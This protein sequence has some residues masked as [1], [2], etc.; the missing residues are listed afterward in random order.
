MR[1]HLQQRGR[2]SW[3]RKVFVGRSSDGKRRYVE[4]TV[5]GSRRD[6]ERA[7]ARLVV[8][9]DEG[10]YAAA[11]PM[12]FGELLDWW[13]AVKKLAVEPTTLSSYE[14]VAR[15]YLRPALADRK[16]T[17]LR[18]IELDSLPSP[19]AQRQRVRLAA[20]SSAEDRSLDRPTPRLLRA[21]TGS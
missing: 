10:R 7:L 4:R 15:K 18:A 3:R 20:C 19:D 16:L 17:S 11:A 12:T 2:D 5:R 21:T 9:A 1:G 14:W 13:L 6:A 8:E